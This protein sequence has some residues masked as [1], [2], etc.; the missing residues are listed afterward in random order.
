MLPLGEA[1]SAPEGESIQLCSA[2]FS[3]FAFSSDEDTAIERDN[4]VRDIMERGRFRLRQRRQRY[5]SSTS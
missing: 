2:T 4:E 5:A 1:Y 3:R